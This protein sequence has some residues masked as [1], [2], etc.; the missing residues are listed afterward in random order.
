MQF[1]RPLDFDNASLDPPG[2]YQAQFMYNGESCRVI[3]TKVPAGASGP[4]NHSHP[5]GDQLY[6]V[7]DG[8]TTIKLGREVL[9]A[10]RHSLVF[11]P[12]GVPH[13]SWNEGD[14]T[15]LH[16]EVLAPPPHPLARSTEPT[17]SEEANGLG[18]Y[19]AQADDSRLGGSAFVVDW[20]LD[21]DRGGSHMGLYRAEVPAAAGGPPLHFHGFDQFYFVLEGTLT[22]QIGLTCYDVTPNNL[23]VLP[24][25]VPHSQWNKGDV[26]E[27][28]IAILSPLP[29]ERSRPGARWD[30]A[31]TL[32]EAPEEI[33]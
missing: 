18:Y 13:H 9:K 11:I 3:A 33:R 27:R 7:L 17:D 19:I 8:E 25:G 21:R 10:P 29:A 4:P 1:V 12:A 20:L 31:V 28:H 24:A 30:V 6:F 2:G 5:T 16:I 15:E 14:Q 23:V 32:G 22:V 26:P